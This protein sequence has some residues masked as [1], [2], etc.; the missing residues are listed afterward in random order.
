[1]S[2]PKAQDVARITDFPSP[3]VELA[4]ERAEGGVSGFLL[5]IDGSKYHPKQRL[6]VEHQEAL[7][8]CR[9]GYRSCS[10]S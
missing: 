4:P 9:T 10:F 1:M 8:A 2:G 7:L 6:L 5:E 3:E